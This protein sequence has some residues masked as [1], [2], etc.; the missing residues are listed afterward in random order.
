WGTGF[1]GS[2]FPKPSTLP[3]FDLDPLFNAIENPSAITEEAAFNSLRD[4]LLDSFDRLAAN[5]LDVKLGNNRHLGLGAYIRT[6]TPLRAY[7]N[8]SFAEKI[9]LTNRIS[10]ELFLPATEKRFYINKISEQAFNERNFKD[11]D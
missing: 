9:K 6:K 7:M 4:F 8:N 10:V 11:L 1:L 3:T 5:L 2:S